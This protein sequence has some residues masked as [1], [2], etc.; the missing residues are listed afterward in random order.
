M[1][2]Y[3]IALK[4][5]PPES[6]SLYPQEYKD[7]GLFVYEH[8]I[9]AV[10]SFIGSKNVPETVEQMKLALIH[11]I[12]ELAIKKGCDTDNLQG[13]LRISIEVMDQDPS[14]INICPQNLFTLLAMNGIFVPQHRLEGKTEW[15]VGNVKFRYFNG[16]GEII[17]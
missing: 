2:R 7:A 15:V 10:K 12:R 13:E 14:T 1:D 8:M 5:S 17:V 9:N 3:E 11:A 16:I 4:K 6:L